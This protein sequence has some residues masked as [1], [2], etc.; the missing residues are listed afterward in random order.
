MCGSE[1][2]CE[3]FLLLL[4]YGRK[5]SFHLLIPIG[6]ILKSFQCNVFFVVV[7]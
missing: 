4:F 6:T 3:I 1:I 7:V 2:L 5:R